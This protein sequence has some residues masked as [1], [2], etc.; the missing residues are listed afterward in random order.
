MWIFLEDF[1]DKCIDYKK[2]II[3]NEEENIED[4]FVEEEIPEEWLKKWVKDFE[5]SFGVIWIKI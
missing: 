2:L 4:K 1:L 5:F 3:F